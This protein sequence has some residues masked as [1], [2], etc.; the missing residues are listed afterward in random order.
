MSGVYI[1]EFDIYP[2]VYKIGKS[3]DIDSRYKQFKQNT[4]ILGNVKLIYSKEFEDYSK[5]E[6]DIHLAL[7][8]YRVQENREFFKGNVQEFIK[9]IENLNPEDYKILKNTSTDIENNKE[10]EEEEDFNPNFKE[11]ASILPD[12]IDVRIPNYTKH[13][14]HLLAEINLIGDNT[15]KLLEVT[16]GLINITGTLIKENA[17]LYAIAKH[18]GEEIS[19]LKQQK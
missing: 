3:K 2:G 8:D 11:I 5:A 17:H 13:I 18:H 4:S 1:I 16:N 10:S 12:V 6:S 15:Q 19:K 9:T 7:K 14:L